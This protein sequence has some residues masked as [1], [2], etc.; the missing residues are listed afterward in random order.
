MPWD[1]TTASSAISSTRPYRKARLAALQ[2]DNYQCQYR[3][4]GCT[5]TATQTDHATPLA[6]GGPAADP[7]ALISTCTPCH[8][9][10]TQADAAAGRALRPRERRPT[11]IHPGLT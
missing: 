9:I 10:K 3:L 1:G 11:P 6:R 7:S 5:G 2:R 4:P 8:A